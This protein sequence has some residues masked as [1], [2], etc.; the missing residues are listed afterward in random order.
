VPVLGT[1]FRLAKAIPI[2]PQKEDAAAYERAF[3]EARKVLEEGDLLCIFPEGG[4]TRD[5]RL[6]DFKGGV[7][8]ILQTHPVPVVPMA[9]RNLWGSFFSRVDGAAMTKPFRRGMFT[10]V[11]LEVGEP[12]APQTVTPARL[13]QRVQ[14][15][16]GP[17]AM[18]MAEVPA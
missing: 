3:A 12:M 4:L 14:E 11:G 6:Q 13:R 15:L 17:D 9:L 8:K 16:L 7:M 2:A 10:S 18:P 5:G 1:I